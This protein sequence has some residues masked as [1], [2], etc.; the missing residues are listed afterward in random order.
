MLQHLR[1]K[2]APTLQVQPPLPLSGNYKQDVDDHRCTM[3]EDK[4]TDVQYEMKTDIVL[5]L[6][7]THSGHQ[8]QMLLSAAE[9]LGQ[10]VHAEVLVLAGVNPD[11]VLLRVRDPVEEDP[12]RLPDGLLANCTKIMERYRRLTLTFLRKCITRHL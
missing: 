12:E 5:C 4:K 6:C 9:V 11:S 8:L 1:G 3:E 7:W 10:L 2:S